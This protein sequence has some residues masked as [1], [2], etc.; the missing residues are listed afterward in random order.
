MRFDTNEYCQIATIQA[1]EAIRMNITEKGY[2]ETLV[3]SQ[4]IKKIEQIDEVYVNNESDR[5]DDKAAAGNIVYIQCRV[6]C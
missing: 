1:R 3:I 4:L 2:K 5:L 6:M